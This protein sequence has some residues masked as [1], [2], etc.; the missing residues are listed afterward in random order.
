MSKRDTGPESELG[1]VVQMLDCL[2]NRITAIK[3]KA[4]NAFLPGPDALEEAKHHYNS[5]RARD[6]LF[7]CAD[8]FGEPAWDM[9]VDLFIAGEEGK[10]ISVSSL[11]IAAA[12]PMTTALRWITI[13]ESKALIERQADPSD[14]RRQFLS[15]APDARAKIKQHFERKQSLA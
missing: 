12:V 4:V 10:Q 13:L 7:G 5:R 14:S 15:L 11:C 9:L 3:Q 6:N 8:L 2:E 1:V